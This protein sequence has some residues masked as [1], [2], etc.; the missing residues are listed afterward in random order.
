M[1]YSCGNQ[2]A[3]WLDCEGTPLAG[4]GACWA[5]SGGGCGCQASLLAP[6]SAI[7]ET[8]CFVT[9]GFRYCRCLVNG[10]DVGECTSPTGPIDSCDPFYGCCAPVFFVGF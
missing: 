3:S 1:E 8:S 9:G 7:Y 5:D 6:G 4:T 10:M 2:L